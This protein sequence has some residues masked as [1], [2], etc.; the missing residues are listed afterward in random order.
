MQEPLL[1]AGCAYRGEGLAFHRSRWAQGALR[2]LMRSM[3]DRHIIG[4]RCGMLLTQHTPW[5][6]QQACFDR[7]YS[8]NM[9]DGRCSIPPSDSPAAVGGGLLAVVVACLWISFNGHNRCDVMSHA[10]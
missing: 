6:G 4:T 3:V 5:L 10:A 7:I 9:V 2:D 1:L 8:H